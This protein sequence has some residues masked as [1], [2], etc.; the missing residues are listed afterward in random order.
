MAVLQINGVNVVNP[1]QLTWTLS[2][3]SSD[4]S[5]RNSAGSMM[6]DRIAQKVKLSCQWAFLSQADAATLLQAINTNIFFS[7]TYPDALQGRT[8]TNTFYVGDRTVPMFSFQN[9]VSG[10]QNIAFD[11]I[12]Q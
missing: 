11:L 4:N 7:V 9:G 6:K 8:V 5:G 2:D 12:Q 10:W 1:T 3:I